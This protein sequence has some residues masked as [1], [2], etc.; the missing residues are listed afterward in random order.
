ML[1]V[2]MVDDDH[3]DSAPT[4]PFQASS[5]APC[6]RASTCS[7]VANGI[8]AIFIV[9]HNVAEI[10]EIERELAS[11]GRTDIT[12]FS[13]ALAPAL[14]FVFECKKLVPPPSGKSSRP[15]YAE[16]GVLRFVNG[17]YARG[18]DINPRGCQCR[19]PM[20]LL[21]PARMSI[22]AWL[23]PNETMH[24]YGSLPVAEAGLSSTARMVSKPHNATKQTTGM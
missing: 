6:S 15:Q 12:Y 10:D 11:R 8:S 20:P 18:G 19:S 3:A 13:D 21:L 24:A 17:I 16:H 4:L 22:P 2:R 14:E 7:A 23:P 1:D 5:H 9:E